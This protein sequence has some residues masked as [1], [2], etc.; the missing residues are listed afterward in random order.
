MFKTH[1]FII[2]GY[3][4]FLTLFF[5]ASFIWLENPI[6]VSGSAMIVTVPIYTVTIIGFIY[7][8]I[9]IWN[10]KLL[11]KFAST[12]LAIAVLTFSIFASQVPKYS[13]QFVEYKL[14]QYGYRSYEKFP[15]IFQENKT[16]F[17]RVASEIRTKIGNQPCDK[18]TIT[19]KQFVTLKQ[20]FLGI[21]LRL[22]PVCIGRE[23][24]I[25]VMTPPPF[26]EADLWGIKYFIDW[27]QKLDLEK[28]CGKA[29][30]HKV[31]P[32]WVEYIL[33]N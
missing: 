11:Q 12:L 19:E 14:S 17:E 7:F 33:S 5:Y 8:A 22:Y 18:N 13:E 29:T 23:I 24:N 6:S 1:R 21:S 2:F 10:I 26:E 30:C 3:L 9:R 15:M 31:A 20:S 32:G 25:P 28:M 16:E 27:K 4:L